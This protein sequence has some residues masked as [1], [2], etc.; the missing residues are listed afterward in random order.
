MTL[1]IAK[2]VFYGTVNLGTRFQLAGGIGFIAIGISRWFGS[3]WLGK[4]ME[5]DRARHARDLEA[6]KR[7][8][9]RTVLVTRTQF[10]TEFNAMKLVLYF[11]SSHR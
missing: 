8:L 4:A 6:Y 5:A 2:P 9:D 11:K 10:E 7:E 3:L 1:E